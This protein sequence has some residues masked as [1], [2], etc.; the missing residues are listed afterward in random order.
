MIS[1]LI[2]GGL[3]ILFNEIT[4]ERERSKLEKMVIEKEIIVDG[5]Y[6]FCIK[7]DIEH[8]CGMRSSNHMIK[9]S[10]TKKQ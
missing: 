9:T 6:V 8:G 5:N 4:F 1:E 7:N 3:K 2:G 10:I